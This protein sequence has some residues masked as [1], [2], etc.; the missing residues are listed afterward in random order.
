VSLAFLDGAP[1]FERPLAAGAPM[2]EPSTRERCF[3]LMAEA[4][5]RNWLANDG[6]LV[7]RL[8][9]EVARLHD[10]GCRVLVCNATIAQM[11]ALHALDLSSGEVVVPS[12]TFAATAH[13]SRLE[14]MNPV[15]C[16]ICP[17]TLMAGPDEVERA[18][19]PATRA[20]VPVHLFGNV[21]DVGGL[22]HLAA[23]RGLATLT[24]H[25]WCATSCSTPRTLWRAR[26]VTCQSGGWSRKT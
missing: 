22:E 20:I 17:D 21:G 16:D 24:A 9:T 13:A 12:F 18:V 3:A 1:A 4:F 2:V 8:E 26:L 10:V 23:C 5:G 15:F 19:T 14:G 6:P 25:P 11:L 7:R